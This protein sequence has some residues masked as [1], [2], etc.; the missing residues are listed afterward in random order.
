MLNLI[1]EKVTII[2]TASVPVIKLI[3]DLQKLRDNQAYGENK[4]EEDMRFL[5]IDI[6]FN[7]QQNDSIISDAFGF[8]QPLHMGIKCCNF[9]REKLTIC[10]ILQPITLVLKKFLALKNL[11]SPFLGGLN[12][13]GLIILILSFINGEYREN[14]NTEGTQLQVSRTL[15]CFLYYFGK[16]FDPAH[17]M[18][19]D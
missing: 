9:I 6:T 13:Y 19:S 2:E 15:K 14:Y 17:Y 11:N 18:I 16:L 10:S 3:I 1:I 5:K 8:I 12:S 7:D 4:I